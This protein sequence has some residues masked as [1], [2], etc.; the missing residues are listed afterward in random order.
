M[1][2]TGP[3]HLPPASAVAE[4]EVPAESPPDPNLVCVLESGVKVKRRVPRMR[5][6]SEK[7]E[8]GK[9]CAGHLKRW[10]RFGEDVVRQFGAGAEIYRC[11]KCR[12]L[13]LP[14]P[15]DPRTGSL[16]Y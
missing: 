9:L 14:H 15:D 16:S 8:K 4:A 10:H 7:D 12:T 13:Y 11:E 5:A 2:E 6:C 3:G 1:S